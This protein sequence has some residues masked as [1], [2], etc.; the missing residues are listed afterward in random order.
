MEKITWEQILDLLKKVCKVLNENRVDYLVSGSIAYKLL[1]KEELK[2]HD[3]DI[4]VYKRDF[5]KL[6]SILS[7]PELNL[8]PIKTEFSIHA[9]HKLWTVVDGKPFDLS[10]DS[11]EHYYSNSGFDVTSYKEINIDGVLIKTAS[12]ED[13]MR[14]YKTAL[15][16]GNIDKF[17][18]Y[19]R[20]TIV[21]QETSS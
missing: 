15:A 7:A 10:F 8:N 17:D 13:L 4:V 11:F 9:N 14:I 20:K 19:K 3:A 6:V 12:A 2:I 21:L 18:E 5:D 1:T 16:G